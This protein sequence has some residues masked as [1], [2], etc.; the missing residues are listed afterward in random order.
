ME[1]I[2]EEE[3]GDHSSNGYKY[4]KGLKARELLEVQ[5]KVHKG[6][7]FRNLTRE[8]PVPTPSLF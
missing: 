3:L 2:V 8:L 4:S 1:D 5:K 7:N 6:L